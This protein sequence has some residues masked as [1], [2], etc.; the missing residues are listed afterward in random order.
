V[1][2]HSG[3]YAVWRLE[4]VMTAAAAT[5]VGGAEQ[6]TSTGRGVGA[7][8]ASGDWAPHRRFKLF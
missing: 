3:S 5:V 8:R 1:A 4:A 6:R 7:V 2:R